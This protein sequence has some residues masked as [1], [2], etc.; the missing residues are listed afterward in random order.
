MLQFWLDITNNVFDE[1]VDNSARDAGK[2]RKERYLKKEGKKKIWQVKGHLLCYGV[3]SRGVVAGRAGAV[4]SGYRPSTSL[5]IVRSLAP[6]AYTSTLRRCVPGCVA[7]FVCLQA[8][9]RFLSFPCAD[10]N[11]VVRLFPFP[12]LGGCGNFWVQFLVTFIIIII[13]IIWL[14]FKYPR[15]HLYMR[16]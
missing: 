8:L 9:A 10:Y 16:M 2:R 15:T 5:G 3:E 13:I 1:C 4:T 14:I 6:F 11:R 12:L 7:P